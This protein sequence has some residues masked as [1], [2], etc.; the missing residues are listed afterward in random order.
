MR[1]R[2]LTEDE[3]RYG[4]IF[5]C[6]YQYC[7]GKSHHPGTGRGACEG[8]APAPRRGRD[9]LRRGR[10]RLQVPPGPGRQGTGRDGGAGGGPLPGGAQR[11]GHGALR[12]A[13]GGQ[14][15]VHHPEM[16]GG[17]GGGD[18]LLPVRPLRGPAR[19]AGKEAGA[20]AAH[21]RGGRQAVRPGHHPQGGLGGGFRRSPE[22]GCAEG[23][24]PVP[25]RDRGAGGPGRGARQQPGS[26]DPGP[27]HRP[28]GRLCPL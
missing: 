22:R 20:L 23:P 5:H 19:R 9:P 15:R 14:D 12:P 4:Q 11:E 8:A 16:R 17:R 2:I 13:Q 21:Q 24:G 10:Q 6:G 25:L 1:E 28:R 27:H 7:R 3:V 18:P 26:E